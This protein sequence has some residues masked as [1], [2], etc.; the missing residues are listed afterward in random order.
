MT[1]ETK[2]NKLKISVEWST[3]GTRQISP[4][5]VLIIR[6]ICYALVVI[7]GLATIAIVFAPRDNRNHVPRLGVPGVIELHRP[8]EISPSFENKE[9]GAAPDLQDLQALRSPGGSSQNRINPVRKTVDPSQKNLPQIPRCTGS[10]ADPC[11]EQN[12]KGQD[13][14][15]SVL[16][17]APDGWPALIAPEIEGSGK[18]HFKL[19]S[20]AKIELRV[21]VNQPGSIA[22]FDVC[23]ANCQFAANSSSALRGS[24]GYSLDQSLIYLTVGIYPKNQFLTVPVGGS[25][26]LP[27]WNAGIGMAYAVRPDLS[28]WAAYDHISFV[29][30]GCGSLCS[31]NS[32]NSGRLTDD[33]VTFGFSLRPWD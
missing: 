13:D 12:F 21:D 23:G 30:Q 5:A 24:I 22:P 9:N 31:S 25:N 20:G 27:D 33:R 6:H 17:S 26:T 8:R 1:E 3:S 14:S 7:A 28:I 10:I 19:K 16:P 15:P 2:P 4:N 29:G 11:P 32:Q 18:L